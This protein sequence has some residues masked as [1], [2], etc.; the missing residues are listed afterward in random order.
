MKDIQ[1]LGNNNTEVAKHIVRGCVKACTEFSE[2][3]ELIVA[4]RPVGVMLLGAYANVFNPTEDK[5]PFTVDIGVGAIGHNIASFEYADG[6]GAGVMELDPVVTLA[7]ENVVVTLDEE[8][9]KGSSICIFV[10]YLNMTTHAADNVSEVPNLCE[11]PTDCNY[12]G[13]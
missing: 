5:V 8:M 10:E 1:Y 4:T 13:N 3:D 2:G 6:T 7:S 9:P 11:C 12:Y